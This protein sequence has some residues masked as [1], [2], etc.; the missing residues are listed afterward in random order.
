MQAICGKHT[1]DDK[2]VNVDQN[3]YVTSKYIST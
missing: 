2:V 3:E 1:I